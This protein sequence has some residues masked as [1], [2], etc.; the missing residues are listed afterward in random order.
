MAQL[1]NFLRL[2]KNQ[3]LHNHFL[4]HIPGDYGLPFVGKAV[5]VFNELPELVHEHKEQFGDVSR[6]RFGHQNGVLVSGAENFAQ[7][8]N[9]EK[10]NFSA[11]MGYDKTLGVLYPETLLLSDFE[12]HGQLRKLY[13]EAMSSEAMKSY[14][15]NVNEIIESHLDTLDDGDEILIYEFV[16]SALM[17]VSL[18]VFFGLEDLDSAQAEQ[19]MKSYSNAQE[20]LIS[21]LRKE[22][23][24]LTVSKGLTGVKYQHAFLR[25]LVRERRG[26]EGDDVLTKL[27]NTLDENGEYYDEDLVVKQ[28]AFLLFAAHETTASAITYMMYQT[29]DYSN[30]QERLREKALSLRPEP[31]LHA[32]DLESLPQMTWVMNESLRLHPVLPM[33]ARR[34][35]NSCMIDGQAIPSNTVLWLSPLANHMSE[36][37]WSNPE[38]FDPERFSPERREHMNHAYS[39]VPFGGGAH[40]CVG[41]QFAS[42]IVKSFM[43]Q[44]LHRFEYRLPTDYQLENRYVPTSKPKD[45]LPMIINRLDMVDADMHC[46]KGFKRY[47]SN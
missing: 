17:D 14:Q 44:F 15:H 36:E 27:C 24:N 39:Y 38:K 6:I 43:H 32:E 21:I 34:T 29:A 8:F 42:M 22:V 1:A 40:Q 12:E 46:R 2:P 28:A 20:G 47:C 9:D 7:I 23:P 41:M 26:V 11:Q 31:P 3:K 19:L 10:N 30:W 5:Q 4:S 33:L 37:Y 18:S 45:G 16:K 25:K 13:Q 35:V